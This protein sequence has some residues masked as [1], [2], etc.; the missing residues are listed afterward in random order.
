L[1][2]IEN[3]LKPYGYIMNADVGEFCGVSAVTSNPILA[4]LTRN[5]R[6]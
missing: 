4:E 5:R 3:F 1:E 6:R 2:K